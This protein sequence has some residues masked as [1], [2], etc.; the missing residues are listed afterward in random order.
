MDA[1]AVVPAMLILKAELFTPE[2][3]DEGTERREN[4]GGVK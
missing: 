2:E 1:L 3:K 4:V